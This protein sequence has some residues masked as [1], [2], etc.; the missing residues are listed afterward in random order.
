MRR[1]IGGTNN[2]S[3]VK[4]ATTRNNGRYNGNGR[5]WMTPPDIFN[6]L[7]QEFQFTLDPCSTI[8]NALVKKYYTEK[9]NGL[10]Q[11]WHG[12]RVFMN[13]PYGKEIYAWVEKAR[14]E[15]DNGALVVGLLPASTDLSWWHEHVV[16]IAEIRY[17]RGRVRFLTGGAYRASGFFASVIVV[18]RPSGRRLKPTDRA[19]ELIIAIIDSVDGDHRSIDETLPIAIIALQREREEAAERARNCEA[20]CE[21]DESESWGWQLCREDAYNAILADYGFS[22][23]E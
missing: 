12:E 23:K 9:E 19:R 14:R 15:A 22:V 1:T 13:P 8:Q 6:A 21:M 11:S 20:S 7:N 5:E 4:S 16:G 3:V 18:W 10:A 17:I 2:S